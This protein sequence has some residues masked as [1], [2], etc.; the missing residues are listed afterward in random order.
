MLAKIAHTTDFSAQ[1][2]TTGR[3]GLVDAFRGSTT[4]RVLA[5]SRCPV[6][7]LPLVSAGA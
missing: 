6:L 5:Q 7:T 2:M 3:H 1:S 4:S